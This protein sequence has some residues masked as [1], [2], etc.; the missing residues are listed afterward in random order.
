[1]L[2]R[3]QIEALTRRVMVLEDAL[4][5]AHERVGAEAY[6]RSKA[7]AERTRAEERAVSLEAEIAELRLAYD[8]LDAQRARAVERL[9]WYEARA[10][11][12]CG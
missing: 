2:E 11:R 3:A 7:E 12:R 9:G 8:E 1:M 6:L 4:R 5:V 10:T